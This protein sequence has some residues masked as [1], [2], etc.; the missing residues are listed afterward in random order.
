MI[1]TSLEKDERLKGFVKNQRR[2][3]LSFSFTFFCPQGTYTGTCNFLDLF[4][5]YT[6]KKKIRVLLLQ[7]DAV[8]VVEVHYDPFKIGFFF[9]SME[10]Q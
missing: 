6:E 4:V 5:K 7:I 2:T 10:F 8:K 1:S 3:S 9:W